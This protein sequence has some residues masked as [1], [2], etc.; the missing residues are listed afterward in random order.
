VFKK[1]SKHDYF[2][3]K[4]AK[5]RSFLAKKHQKTLIFTPIFSPKTNK[6]YKI[7]I[8]T[9]TNHPIFQKNRQKPLNF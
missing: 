5:R 3:Q 6:S 8:L 2:L 7:T 4:V 9:I 1:C